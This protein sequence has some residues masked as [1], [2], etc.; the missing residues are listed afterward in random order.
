MSNKLQEEA[1]IRRKH[2]KEASQKIPMVI[3]ISL[4]ENNE[5]EISNSKQALKL[6]LNRVLIFSYSVPLEEKI[7]SFEKMSK[8]ADYLVIIGN[9]ISREAKAINQKL[10]VIVN[11]NSKLKVINQT[12]FRLSALSRKKTTEIKSIQEIKK[13]FS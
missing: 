3:I 2:I 8:E 5:N 12:G 1:R 4:E 10:N 6:A 13:V 9:S 11:Y 7:Y